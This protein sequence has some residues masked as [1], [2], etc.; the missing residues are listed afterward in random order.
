[1]LKSETP[2]ECALVAITSMAY[3]ASREPLDRRNLPTISWCT[4]RDSSSCG[5]EL[6]RLAWAKAVARL[7]P[8]SAH[9]IPVLSTPSFV[10]VSRSFS[11][12]QRARAI[13]SY[14]TDN[15]LS[16]STPSPSPSLLDVFNAAWDYAGVDSKEKYAEVTLWSWL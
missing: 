15:T 14:F 12:F 5:E 13:P 6:D 10:D 4:A 16:R 2:T 11:L 1:M 3:V 8:L 9:S 7:K